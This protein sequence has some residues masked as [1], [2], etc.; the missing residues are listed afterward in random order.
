MKAIAD[1]TKTRQEVLQ[2][3]AIPMQFINLVLA[4]EWPSIKNDI[5]A[6]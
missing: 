2:Q 3:A 5:C 4:D 6:I 1:G